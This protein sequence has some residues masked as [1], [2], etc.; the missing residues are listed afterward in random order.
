[1]LIVPLGGSQCL[2]S[3]LLLGFTFVLTV[4]PVCA[5]LMTSHVDSAQHYSILKRA[6]H[7]LDYTNWNYL[8]ALQLK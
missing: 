6:H 1:M 8:S 2:S 5:V 3:K 4:A 7:V